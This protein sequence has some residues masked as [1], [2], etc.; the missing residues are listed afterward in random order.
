MKRHV[1]GS[2]RYL[3]SLGTYICIGSA[4]AL[5]VYQVDSNAWHGVDAERF[6]QMARLIIDGA[7]P[8]VHFT[9]PKPPLL[10]F[11]VALM[12]WIGA[13]TGS[14]DLP[15]MTGIY[16]LCAFLIFHIGNSDY[17]VITGYTS[18]LLFLTAGTL[19][20][21]YLLFSEPFA[22]LF[23]LLAFL[24]IRER[25]LIAAGVCIG[26]AIGFKQY[27]LIGIVPLVYYLWAQG[28][29]R[30]HRL[31]VPALVAVILPF[32]ATSLLYGY[33]VTLSALSWTFG[34][35]P[36]YVMGQTI[37][38]IPNYRANGLFSFAV[39]LIASVTMVFP[40]LILAIVSVIRRGL[41]SPSEWMIALFA[42]ML[43]G[44]IFIRQYLH[45]WILILP[46]L[47]LLVCREFAD[48][49]HDTQDSIL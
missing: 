48:E 28:D 23:L 2:R 17:G 11:V 9:D 24:L 32:L 18:G 47:V 27:A 39:N 35:G 4:L 1:W 10:F 26:L 33:D 5:I 22:L 45:Y 41:R 16:V 12:D 7:S 13:S 37:A 19:V 46:F 20:Q 38:D 29:T 14:L 3:I 31:L 43:G 8:Y 40:T 21:G 42:L 30:Y 34:I 49:A 44:T 6:H 25:W 15:V 36:A